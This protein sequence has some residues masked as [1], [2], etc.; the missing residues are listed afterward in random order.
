M[1]SI[2]EKTTNYEIKNNW[3]DYSKEIRENI[4]KK[5]VLDILTY[6]VDLDEVCEFII[7]KENNEDKIE[8]TK[9]DFISQ[10]ENAKKLNLFIA[11][12]QV[13]ELYINEEYMN[14]GKDI[15]YKT[16]KDEKTGKDIEITKKQVILKHRLVVI[17]Y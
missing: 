10:N 4:V 17:K 7:S 12:R 16:V 9:T 5:S 15:V 8:F 1:L 14:T 6:Y 3:K 13:K 2:T 11:G